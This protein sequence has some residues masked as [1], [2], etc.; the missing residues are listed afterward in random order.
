MGF[1]DLTRVGFISSFSL[2]IID[3]VRFVSLDVLVEAIQFTA[4]APHP[5]GQSLLQQQG[6]RHRGD[7][8]KILVG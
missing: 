8:V 7:R 5:L 6:H 2:V 3:N 4:D 1:S